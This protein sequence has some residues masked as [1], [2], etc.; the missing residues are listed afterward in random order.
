MG[1]WE[2]EDRIP[3]INE[4]QLTVKHGCTEIKG[5]QSSLVCKN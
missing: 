5:A 3:P 2:G 1:E 4:K